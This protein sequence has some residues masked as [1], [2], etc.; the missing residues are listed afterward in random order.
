MSNLQFKDVLSSV[1]HIKGGIPSLRL[2][3]RI[4]L[5]EHRS[6]FF[7]QGDFFDI[8]EYDPDIDLPNM[9]VDLEGEED[10]EYARRCVE[11][12][13]VRLQFIVDLS[14][15]IYAGLNLNRQKML[16]EA[17]GLIGTTAV[18][19]MDPVGLIG[20][21]DK[22]VLN[23][24]ARAGINNFYY[25]LKNVYDFLDRHDLAKK[26]VQSSGT[27]FFA[28]LD[29][30]RKHFNRPY[31]TF[32]ISDFVGL[33]K[34]IDTPLLRYVASKHELIFIFLDDPLE[35]L[36]AKGRGYLSIHNPERNGEKGVVSRKE[37]FRLE[38]YLRDQRRKLRK[39]KLRKMG[40]DSVVLEYSRQGRH[41][42]RLHRFF[43]KRYKMMSAQH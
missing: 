37:L 2:S 36:S 18:R 8:K 12:H 33:E 21:T 23:T 7:G 38:Q 26:R 25:L 14:S 16:L 27:N 4:K 17:I 10:T 6:L 3:S 31:L 11:P 9:K 43:L 42:N 15:S 35:F 30:M 19:Y 20:F 39:N 5:G 41:L 28:P 13:E 1:T 29:F 24:S 32:V 22:I 34:V 40:I